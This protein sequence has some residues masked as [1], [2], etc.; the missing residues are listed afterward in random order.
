MKTI[1]TLLTQSKGWIP[2]Q[3]INDD[4]ESLTSYALHKM[5]EE[6][7]INPKSLNFTFEER[8]TLQDLINDDTITIKPADKGGAVVLLNTKDYIQE[9]ERQLNQP[10]YY[11]KTAY[12]LTRIFTNKIQATISTLMKKKESYHNMLTNHLFTITLDPH[13]SICYQKYMNQNTLDNLSYQE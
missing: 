8:N 7:K 13:P 10:E 4:I 12:D 5:L 3:N 11:R 6:P 1:L 2:P 9:A